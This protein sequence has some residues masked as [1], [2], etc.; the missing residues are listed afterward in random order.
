MK[1]YV[2]DAVEPIIH[3]I[4]EKVESTPREIH[5][6]IVKIRDFLISHTNHDGKLFRFAE[7]LRDEFDRRINIEKGGLTPLH[8]KYLDILDEHDGSPVGVKTI[9]V[10]LGV[11][12]KSVEDDI[13]PLLLKL[14][15]IEKT[16]K[17]RVKI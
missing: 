14:G 11:S 7:S 1:L 3:K 4:E 2:I 13:E 8:R 10:K 16:S 17:G 15:K 5:N 6:F 9:A 12:E